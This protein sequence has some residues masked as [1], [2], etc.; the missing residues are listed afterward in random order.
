VLVDI[1]SWKVCSSNKRLYFSRPG[2]MAMNDLWWCSLYS[3]AV[4]LR[5]LC[6]ITLVSGE[7]FYYDCSWSYFGYIVRG[8][9]WQD[10]WLLSSRIL[11]SSIFWIFLLACFMWCTYNEVPCLSESTRSKRL[12]SLPVHKLPLWMSGV[13]WP[14]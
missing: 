10:S 1:H 12:V 7:N 3:F 4:K 5:K 9:S 13:I 8:S 6:P 2:I 14:G 11:C